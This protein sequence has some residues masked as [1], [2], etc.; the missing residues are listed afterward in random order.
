MNDAMMTRKEIL[1]YGQT[2]IRS[3]AIMR[4]WA[5][6][7]LWAEEGWDGSDGRVGEMCGW[8]SRPENVPRGWILC[9]GKNGTHDLRERSWSEDGRLVLDYDRA[10]MTSQRAPNCIMCTETWYG[11]GDDG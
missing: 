10:F 4:S 5:H 7:M 2:A 9:D 1:A 8:W 11:Q 6:L 3:D